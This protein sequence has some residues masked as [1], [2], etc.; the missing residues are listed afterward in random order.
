MLPTEVDLAE[1][2]GVSR[3]TLRE[4]LSALQFAGYVESRR[5]RG[6]VVLSASPVPG[7]ARHVGAAGS[8]AEV[9][10][11]LEARLAV[12][13]VVLALAAADPDPAA[14]DE[15]Q[16][17]LSGMALVVG[18]DTI[19]ADTDHRL[20]VLIARVCRNPLL[21][22]QVIALLDRASG[23][24]WQQTQAVAWQP[25]AALC[26]E[27]AEDHAGIL[28]ALERGDGVAAAAISRR[29]LLTA[30][31]NAANCAQMPASER[32]RVRRLA[33]RFHAGRGPADP[34]PVP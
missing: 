25:D 27:W 18:A 16:D 4:A 13:P 30:V 8:F 21:R 34:D 7:V 32:W 11:L 9:V 19:P 28:A 33:E 22:E 12:E 17:A 10:D 5:R 31:A 3:P 6:T 20:H 23:P 29:H 15:A 14:L 2:F 24:F 26:R 1:E